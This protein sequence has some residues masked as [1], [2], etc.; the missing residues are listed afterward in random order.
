MIDIQS[1]GPYFTG[2]KLILEPVLANCEKM[3][4]LQNIFLGKQF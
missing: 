3:Q 2:E 4:M 1:S